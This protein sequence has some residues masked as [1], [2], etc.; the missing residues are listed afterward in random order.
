ME[1]GYTKKC[2]RLQKDNKPWELT[3]SHCVEWGGNPIFI[4][5]Q[6]EQTF[7]TKYVKE[8]SAGFEK[9]T[10]N[11]AWLGLTDFYSTD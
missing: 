7:V 4:E 9:F 3:M 8:K 11:G 5:N 2:V 6:E 10:Y 1:V